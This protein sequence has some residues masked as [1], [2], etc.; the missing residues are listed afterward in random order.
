MT[1]KI[2]FTDKGLAMNEL[3]AASKLPGTIHFNPDDATKAAMDPNTLILLKETMVS[4][5][6]L[7]GKGNMNENAS[8]KLRLEGHT[9]LNT[10][11]DRIEL[12]FNY[13]FKKMFKPD[14]RLV[15]IDS[16]VLL[17]MNNAK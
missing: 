7:K 6:A 13:P 14:N 9:P 4:K 12:N 3:T 16:D 1:W 15:D 5:F 17:M 10:T 2:G 11:N 8:F